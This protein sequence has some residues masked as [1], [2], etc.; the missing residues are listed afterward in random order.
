MVNF[1]HQ[2]F[3]QIN[4]G[5]N[6]VSLSGSLLLLLGLLLIPLGLMFRRPFQAANLVQDI[7]LTLVFLICGLI[8]SFQGWRYDPIMQ[9][10]Q[11]LITLSVIYLVMKDI[12][13]H[14]RIVIQSSNRQN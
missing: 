10:G 9:F 6:L 7:V 11:F 2:L 4:L 5:T 13:S 14:I 8:L 12:F 3:I 1:S